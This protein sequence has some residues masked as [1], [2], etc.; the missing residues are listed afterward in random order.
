MATVTTG[1]PTTLLAKY[2]GETPPR[3]LVQ[4]LE[5]LDRANAVRI[6]RAALKR[7][8]KAGR[9]SVVELIER[10]PEYIESMKV[11][12]LLLAAPKLGRVKVNR[13]LMHCRISPSKQLGSGQPFGGGL[14]QRQRDELICL[15]R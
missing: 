5:A 9:M 3:S 11:I 14:S 7:E 1:G 4:R 13:I 6:K 10:P 12:D 2:G 8:L 15:L